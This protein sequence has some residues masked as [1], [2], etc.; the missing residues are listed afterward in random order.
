MHLQFQFQV[1]V[2]D[3]SFE[4]RAGESLRFKS[5]HIFII[6][7]SNRYTKEYH[8]P[9]KR[10]KPADKSIIESLIKFKLD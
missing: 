2:D 5:L 4:I 1:R 6:N 3:Q 9:F 7:W 10:G 8:P